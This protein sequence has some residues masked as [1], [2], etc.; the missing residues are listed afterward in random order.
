M[1]DK[2]NMTSGVGII[3]VYLRLSAVAFFKLSK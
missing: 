3:R 2:S 1:N